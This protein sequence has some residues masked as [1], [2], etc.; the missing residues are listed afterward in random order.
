M[1][2]SLA[3]VGTTGRERNWSTGPEGTEHTSSYR[4]KNPYPELRQYWKL[5]VAEGEKLIF[6]RD[7]PQGRLTS[8]LLHSQAYRSRIDWIQWVIKRRKWKWERHG[9]EYRRN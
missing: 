8:E 1:I 9:W 6:F 4:Y 5:M 7:L 3:A 2:I